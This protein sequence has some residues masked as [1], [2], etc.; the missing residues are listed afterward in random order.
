MLAIDNSGSTHLGCRQAR[1]FRRFRVSRSESTAT[2]FDDIGRIGGE[3]PSESIELDFLLHWQRGVHCP[4]GRGA[5][6]QARLLIAQQLVG[7]EPGE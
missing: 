7:D 2:L 4:F 3:L 1:S 6:I 5:V